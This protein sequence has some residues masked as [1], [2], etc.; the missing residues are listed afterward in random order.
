MRPSHTRNRV[1]HVF[2]QILTRLRSV[3]LP[4][5]ILVYSCARATLDQ[6][7]TDLGI[8]VALAGAVWS[9]HRLSCRLTHPGRSQICP[10]A[11][12][13]T[14]TSRQYHQE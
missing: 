2:W 12:L 1:Y 8:G 10:P 4:M 13:G 11:L 9:A 14:A 7:A 5:L 6:Q 3:A